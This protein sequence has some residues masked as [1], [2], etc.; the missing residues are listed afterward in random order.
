MENGTN[1]NY[2]KAC[3]SPNLQEQYIKIDNLKLT[4]SRIKIQNQFKEFQTSGLS[5]EEF[6]KKNYPKTINHQSNNISK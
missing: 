5:Q 4:D 6:F 3:T 2:N 1:I